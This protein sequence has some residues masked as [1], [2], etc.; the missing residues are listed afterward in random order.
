[1]EKTKILHAIE[2]LLGLDGNKHFINP[3]YLAYFRPE[4]LLAIQK[5]LEKQQQTT[6]SNEERDWL[7]QL[8]DKS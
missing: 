2:E 8:A 4:E 1:M 6:L 7:W 3:E 5:K